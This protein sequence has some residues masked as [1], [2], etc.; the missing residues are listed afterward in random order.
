MRTTIT[1]LLVAALTA[2]LLMSAPALALEPA[3]SSDNTSVRYPWT[4]AAKRYASKRKAVIKVHGV[5]AAGRDI[6]KWGVRHKDGSVTRASFRQIQRSTY[7]LIRIHRPAGKYLARLAVAPSLAPSG[8]KSPGAAPVGLAGCI[9]KYESGGDPMAQNGQYK[10]IAQWSPEA[11]A[12]H[13]GTRFAATPHGATYQ[14][15]LVVLNQ[16]LTRYGCRDWCP[17]DPC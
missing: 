9:V 13:G 2:G 11:W 17:Y 3:G 14:Q 15:Q 12:R 1:R 7:Q 5:Q 10:G 8:V 6:R 4:K 16:G